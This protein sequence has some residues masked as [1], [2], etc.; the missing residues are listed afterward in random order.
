MNISNKIDLPDIEEMFEFIDTIQVLSYEK[1]G[2]ELKI[3]V[4][5]AEIVRKA[6]V[7]PQYFIGGKPPS[8]SYIDS[9]YKI[10]GFNDELVELRDRLTKL[11]S[12]L[13]SIKLKFFFYKDLIDLYRTQ[14]A[15]ERISIV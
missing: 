5:E 6:S 2:L 8:M 15:N 14:S 4:L 3:K 9:T 11:N 12:D 13:D 7:D 10:T 1:A